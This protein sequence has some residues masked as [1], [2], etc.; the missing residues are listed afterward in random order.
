M[1]ELEKYGGRVPT[2]SSLNSALED[3]VSIIT[4]DYLDRLE[5]YEILEPSREILDMNI[6]EIS[7]FYKLTKLVLNKEEN[8]LNKLTTIVNVVSSIGC[9]LSTIIKSDGANVDFYL[10]IITKALRETDSR[11]VSNAKAFHGAVLGNLIGSEIHEVSK[12]ETEKFKEYLLSSEKKSI[13]SVSGVVAMRNKDTHDVSSYVQGIENLVDSLR[14]QK[15]TVIMI[16]DPVDTSEIQQIKTGYETLYTQ[17]S[18]FARNVVTLSEN[19]TASLSSAKTE[20]ITKGISEGIALTQSRTKSISKTRGFNAN[21]GVNFGVLATVGFQGSSGR[22]TSDTAGR[23]D[24]RMESKMMSQSSTSSVSTS[25]MSGKS[26]Q[27]SSENRSVKSLLD[28]IDKHLIRLDECDSFGAFDCAAYVIAEDK[29]TALTV[30]GNYNALMRGMD[31]SVQSSHINLWHDSFKTQ[32]LGQYLAAMYHPRFIKDDNRYGSGR[33]M[34]SFDRKSDEIIVTPAT[35]ISGNELSMQVG[36]PK[37]SITGVTVIPMAPFGRNISATPGD[38]ISLG[39]LYHMGSEETNGRTVDIDIQSLAAH[40]FITGSTGAGKTTVISS[41]LDKLSEKRIKFLVIEPAKGEYKDKFGSRED[42][43]IYGTNSA[44]MPLLRINPFSFPEDIHVLEHIDRLIEIF[45]VC[46]P[47]YAAMPAI[48]KDSVERAYYAAGW[49]LE[50]SKC[51]YSGIFGRP[52]FPTFVDVLNQINAVMDESLYSADSKGDYK[53]ALC[54]RIR[55]LTNGLYG[56]IFSS[57]EIPPEKLFDENVIVDLSRTGSGETKSLIM[58]L[59]VMKL[60][61][62]RMSKSENHNSLL[63]HVT[64]LEEAHHILKRIHESESTALAAKSVEMLANAI[65]EMRTYGEGFLIADQSPGLMDMS[66][67]RNTNTKILLRL[68]DLGD[69]E[70]VGRAANLS[71][72]QIIELSRLKTFVAAVYQNDWLEPVLCHVD[73]S[74]KDNVA[75][76]YQADSEAEE[77]EIKYRFLNY[78]M[79]PSYATPL[80]IDQIPEMR[81]LVYRMSIPVEAKIAFIKFTG[82]D[83]VNEKNALKARVLYHIFNAELVFGLAKNKKEDIDTWYRYLVDTLEPSIQTMEEGEQKKLISLLLN[84]EMKRFGLKEYQRLMEDFVKYID[85]DGDNHY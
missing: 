54:T 80:Y 55:S 57:D 47:L 15:Y 65:A 51:K 12:L 17:L 10:G 36:L 3:A 11:K 4:K 49:N 29:N 20:G 45:N 5:N 35:I 26:L 22:S 25:K 18:T 85:R 34:R 39:S 72:E 40:T 24:S 53:G 31:S 7:N 37:K 73:H 61:E 67:I 82:E 59:L 60:Q 41:M 77:T 21:I 68:P 38:K 71:E 63:K 62:Y 46:W 66:V 19:D 56:Q 43:S 52:V 74:F 79:I 58:G 8:F 83:D 76:S 14:G 9:S 23:T 28:K 16:A 84:E 13:S 30:A 32:K 48:L 1:N 75:Y 27:L 64:V 81:E 6:T 70:L 42:V 69:R 44:K 2:A 50:T 78:L 33:T